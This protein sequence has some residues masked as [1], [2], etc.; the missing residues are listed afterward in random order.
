[1]ADPGGRVDSG[2]YRVRGSVGNE[3]WAGSGWYGVAVG[4]GRFGLWHGRGRSGMG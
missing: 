3:V 4:S 1:M 2:W